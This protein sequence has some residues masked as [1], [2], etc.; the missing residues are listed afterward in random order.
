MAM[1]FALPTLGLS[2]GLLLCLPTT[3]DAADASKL[4]AARGK[5][6]L[7]DKCGR[8]HAIEAV[9]ES[10]L[11][12]APPMRGIYTRFDLRDLEARLREGIG[13]THK[14]MPQIQFSDDDVYA[15]LSY[16]YVLSSGSR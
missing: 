3:L 15:I 2:I 1:R 10:P 14:Q 16:L 8:C 4:A 11:K 6:I 12:N 13:S 9:G 7:Q 5:V